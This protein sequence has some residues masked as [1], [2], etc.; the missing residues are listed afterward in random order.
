MICS[1]VIITKSLRRVG[2]GRAYY[3]P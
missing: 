3:R 2:Y 1:R